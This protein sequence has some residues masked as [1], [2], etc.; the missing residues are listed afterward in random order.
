[1]N[2]PHH[3][4]FFKKQMPSTL[5]C[6]EFDCLSL[7]PIVMVSP[8]SLRKAKPTINKVKKLHKLVWYKYK[9]N[10]LEYYYFFLPTHLKPITEAIN[11]VFLNIM[12]RIFQT[13][14]LKFVGLLVQCIVQ[15]VV[16]HLP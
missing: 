12:R 16:Y 9:T 4:L 2:A 14:R 11:I 10:E 1:M 7:R 8:R 15:T 6:E 5:R 3:K 13:L